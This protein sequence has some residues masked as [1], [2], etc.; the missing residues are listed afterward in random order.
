MSDKKLLS[1]MKATGSNL[2][3]EAVCPDLFLCAF[4]SVVPG[5]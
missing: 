4:S 2:G 5:K 1:I 3:L